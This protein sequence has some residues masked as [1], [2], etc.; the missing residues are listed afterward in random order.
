MTHSPLLGAMPISLLLGIWANV[1]PIG[2]WESLA[3]GA[4][5]TFCWFPKFPPPHTH[6]YLFSFL[7][8]ALWISLLSLPKPDSEIPLIPLPSHLPPRLQC[9][10]GTYKIFG[11]HDKTNIGDIDKEFHAKAIV[12]IPQ[13]LKKKSL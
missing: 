5:G 3:S 11:H 13:H 10:N 2:S 12:N 1:I 9:M 7:L 4:S 8:L 6:C